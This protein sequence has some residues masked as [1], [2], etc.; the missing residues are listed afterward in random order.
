MS[1]MPL[2]VDHVT[3]A[4]ARLGPLEQA[5][6][7]VGLKPE[8]GGPH[9]NGITHMAL[10]SF[11]D[12]SYIELIS[13]LEPG[14]ISPLW[15]THIAG[16][17]GPCAWAV[18]VDDVAAEAARLA[19]LGVPVAG[20]TYLNRRRPD[21]VLVEWD[22]AF[23]GSGGPGAT[24]PFI[25]KDRTPRVWRV[26][27]STQVAEAG[28]RGVAMVVLGV[29]HLDRSIDL[30]RRL[31][32][33]PAPQTGEDADLGARLAHFPGTPVTL[34]AAPQK[35]GWLAERLARFGESPCAFL[36]G[37]SDVEATARRFSFAG[38]GSWFGRWIRWL[39][40]AR[41]KGIR[42]GLVAEG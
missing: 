42:L 16:D 5:F 34:A 41:L 8:Y 19:A 29:E 40:P 31:Y 2:K 26:P 15:H 4:G 7:S 24:L 38:A 18:E 27:P 33:W 22:L 10:L 3:I 25:I 11:A 12:G 21:G 37:A 36:L 1:P 23:L 13:T 32:G 35:S 28:L 39:D 20:P 17:G 9:S 6:T 14:Q 30:F